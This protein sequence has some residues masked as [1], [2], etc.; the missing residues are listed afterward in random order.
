[1]NLSNHPFSMPSRAEERSDFPLYPESPNMYSP[2]TFPYS[3]PNPMFP[4]SDVYTDNP[5]TTA[6]NPSTLYAEAPVYNSPEM[7]GAPSNYST[8]N[9]APSSAMGSPH[10]YHGQF[11]PAPQEW[12]TLNVGPPVIASYDN[13]YTPGSE[14]SSFQTTGMED[15]FAL[16]E[17]VPK[18]PG[19]VGESTHI[20]STASRQLGSMSSRAEPTSSVS[21]MASP[22]STRRES[23]SVSASFS[24]P[25]SSR[26]PSQAFTPSSFASSSSTGRASDTQSPTEVQTPYR[27]SHFFS[28][29]SGNFVP[30][31][32]SSC[33]FLSVKRLLVALH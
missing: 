7:R 20:S 12:P 1:M 24:S 18:A 6:F 21:S 8:G 5:V 2:P 28:Q 14:F 15:N 9:S 10:S 4:F 22:I 32:Q 13:Q 23:I 3:A 27:Q 11:A 17:F 19:F 31:L 30:P 33:R 26:R 29:S 25:S 16:Q